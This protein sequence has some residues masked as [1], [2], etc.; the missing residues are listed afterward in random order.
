M[1]VLHLTKRNIVGELFVSWPCHLRG[2]T[3]K[4]FISRDTCSDRVTKVVRAFCM[5]HCTSMRDMH[6]MQMCLPESKYQGGDRPF[7]GV[8]TSLK[9]YRSDG[10]AILRDMGPL[11]LSPKDSRS[12]VL[13]LS[14]G[15]D[16][17]KSTTVPFAKFSFSLKS[18]MN[19]SKTLQN[20]DG[21]E[22]LVLE[23]R[24]RRLHKLSRTPCLACKTK[25]RHY[26]DSINNS[27]FLFPLQPP[28]PS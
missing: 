21:H 27:D 24:C 3:A 25:L 22:T 23:G 18:P 7:W 13:S 1:I 6:H 16:N 20:F 4:L 11:S 19:T 17:Y 10:I 14:S 15:R 8:R 26:N 5:V 2:P 12:L 28:C 9:R